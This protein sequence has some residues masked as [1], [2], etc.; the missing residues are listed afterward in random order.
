MLSM[1]GPARPRSS[2]KVWIGSKPS[3][4]CGGYTCAAPRRAASSGAEATRGA[5]GQSRRA[6]PQAVHRAALGAQCDVRGCTRGARGCGEW[7]R[8]VPTW[9]GM[10]VS[11]GNERCTCGSAVFFRNMHRTRDVTTWIGCQ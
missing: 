4:E 6:R 9:R 2:E 8:V 5:A 10:S 1:T 3:F 11:D 7:F